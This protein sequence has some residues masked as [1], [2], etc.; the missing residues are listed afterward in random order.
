M[1]IVH[2][3]SANIVP[4]LNK[5]REIRKALGTDA[6]RGGV[7]A[8]TC[9]HYLYFSSTDIPRGSSEYK[10]APPIRD[11]KNKVTYLILI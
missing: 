11:E 1:H 7:T 4:M 6:W 2:V 3:S 5:A 8:E 9:H 10:C